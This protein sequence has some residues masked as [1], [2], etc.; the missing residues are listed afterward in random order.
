MKTI[1]K[2]GLALVALLMTMLS[3]S[4]CDRNRGEEDTSL[5]DINDFVGMWSCF[6][7][8]RAEILIIKAD[9]TAVSTCLE[10]DENYWENAEG[11][12]EIDKDIITISI[13]NQY[14]FSGSFDIVPGEKLYLIDKKT[15]KGT[16]YRYCEK[17][18]SEDVL[19]SWYCMQ[20]ILGYEN[21]ISLMT[22][23]DN[24]KYLFSL[25]DQDGNN[26]TFEAAYKVVGD[27]FFDIALEESGE[28][29]TDKFVMRLDYTPDAT[30][31]GD[32]MIQSAIFVIDDES[33]EA[34]VK[35]LRMNEVPDLRGLTYN[36]NHSYVCQAEGLDE[37]LDFMGFDFNF[38]DRD[39]VQLEALLK[40][41]DFVVEFSATE[42]ISF[43]F[44]C[45]GETVK[46]EMPVVVDSNYVSVQMSQLDA[47]YR[48]VDLF[49]LQDAKKHHVRMYM[50]TE[51]FIHFFGNL[52][53][54]ILSQQQQLDSKDTAAVD[55]IFK[56]LDDAIESIS[57]SLIMNQ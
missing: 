56:R 6:K 51:D 13:D 53:V 36:Y 37:T 33:Y 27:L 16:S 57:V 55:A 1:K 43:S 31:S 24:G 7:A 4:S 3:F 42:T 25:Y 39:A 41:I 29:G 35:Y 14:E 19:G 10:N 32:E 52:Q 2:L 26:Q 22:I 34:S 20:G 46:M 54:A 30:S 50:Y 18:L 9:G 38:S 45:Q 49:V 28:V 21:E 40:A 47:A 8:N 12:V 15:G 23:Q 48:D 44:Q 11:R 17:D 5:Y